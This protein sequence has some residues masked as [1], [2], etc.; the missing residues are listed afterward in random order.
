[1]NKL[2]IPCIIAGGSGTRLWPVSRETMPKPFIRLNDGYTL[3]QKTIQRIQPLCTEQTVVTVLNRELMFRILDDFRTLQTEPL[4]LDL[5][6]EPF[7]RNTAAAA[8]LCALHVQQRWGDQ[9]NMLLLPADH[10]IGDVQEFH[11]AV[12]Q[13]A[14]L[15][16]QGYLVTFGL[17][18]DNPETGYGYIKQGSVLEH[19][20][21]K[22][23]EFCEKPDLATAEHFL[24]SGE[25]LWNSGM[26]CMS[27][28]TL[29]DEA[30]RLTP[31]LL[32]HV[33]ASW[34]AAHPLN[35]ADSHSIEVS[36][37]EFSQADNV[38]I[39]V[40]IMER[41]EKVAVVPCALKWSDIG[42]WSAMCELSEAD[43]QGNRCVGE[44]MLHDSNNCYIDSPS[45][46]TAVI[47]LD[48]VIVVDTPDALL[49]TSKSH[50]QD[51]RVIA[52][53]LKQA[54]HSAYLNHLTM[55]R[56]WGMYSVLNE[57]ESYKIKRIKVKPGAS[58][59][60]QA[61]FHRSEHWIVVSG[62]AEVVNGERSMLLRTNES[63]FIRTGEK[64]RLSNP[65]LIDLVIIEVQSGEYLGE[66]D[67]VRF[68]DNYGRT[69]QGTA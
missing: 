51:V 16:E 32:A 13:A 34:A 63:T 44:T 42:S 47:G 18:P 39:D 40:A 30:E 35:H 59:S 64:H 46:M 33:R 8:L 54:G 4:T 62:T 43:S 38:S 31:Q 52:N 25:Y 7:G 45:R 57:S 69:K 37:Q 6:L 24:A 68:D 36:A 22:V 11:Q 17:Q 48:D 1:M 65:G 15:A 26:F 23:A 12:G 20:G 27:A 19:G 14:E 10:I 21:Y 67:I 60:L 56:P 5:I 66:D 61:H 28:Q 49:V 55:I 29:L 53:K 50:S 41:S 3:L 58:L 2:L 9:A